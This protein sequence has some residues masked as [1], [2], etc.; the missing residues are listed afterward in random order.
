MDA[1]LK[2][3]ANEKA[4]TAYVSRTLDHDALLYTLM[5]HAH[6]R[7]TA[8]QYVAQYPD[9]REEILLS[10]PRYDFKWQTTYEFTT[11]KLLPKG[12][13]VTYS[14]TYDNST[15]NKS[16]P[17]PNIEVR[18]GEQT[19]QEMIYG[20]MRFRYLGETAGDELKTTSA[21]AP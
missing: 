14:T 17:D 9:G 6:V 21:E 3:P 10:V 7:G 19:W 12:T 18:W 11:P 4:Y 5:P 13:K 2:I 16:N 1:R 20:D 8:A 15:Q